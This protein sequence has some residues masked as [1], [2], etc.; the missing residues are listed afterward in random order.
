MIQNANQRLVWVDESVGFHRGCAKSTGWKRE[1]QPAA[2][3]S[4]M[5]LGVYAVRSAPLKFMV[6]DLP[7]LR[8]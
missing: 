8:N 1:K 3:N 5:P 2:A 4:K 7:R 6:A